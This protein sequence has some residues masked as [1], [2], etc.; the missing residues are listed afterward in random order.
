MSIISNKARKTDINPELIGAKS[1]LN[2]NNDK[3]TVN[4]SL[5]ITYSNNKKL[6]FVNGDD[7]DDEEEDEE[8][9]DSLN[10]AD[11]NDARLQISTSP[12]SITKFAL[13]GSNRNLEATRK[14]KSA[15][16]TKDCDQ[17]ENDNS[18]SNSCSYDDDDRL[19]E[20]LDY[21]E[22]SVKNS[23]QN[24]KNDIAL[25][26]KSTISVKTCFRRGELANVE[27]SNRT[28]S[29]SEHSSGSQSE[30]NQRD[31]QSST[32]LTN[33]NTSIGGFQS[34]IKSFISLNQATSQDNGFSNGVDKEIGEDKSHKRYQELLKYFFK[35]ACFFQIKSINYENVELSKS[36]GV[37]ST[38]FQNEIR[39]NTAFKENRNVILIFS[40]Q[41]SGAFQGFAR[42]TSPSQP[43]DR[44]VPWILPERMSNK[45]LGGLFKID[46]LCTKELSFQETKDLTNP[47]NGN[48]P[49]KIARDGQQLESSI[50]KRLCKLFPRDSKSRLLTCLSTLKR[51][52]SQRKKHKN[53]CFYPLP[54]RRELF[55]ERVRPQDYASIFGLRSNPNEVDF[56]GKIHS[57]MS[58]GLPRPPYANFRP[59]GRRRG[60]PE[61]NHDMNNRQ[62]IYP[63]HFGPNRPPYHMPI[64]ADGAMSRFA[65]SSDHSDFVRFN[66]G[67]PSPTAEVD[68]SVMNIPNPGCRYH[69]YQRLRR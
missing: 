62:Q 57:Y 31:D 41:Q 40:V 6:S 20:G 63:N 49:V 5:P 44:K 54:G 64:G 23:P 8:Q 65:I 37:W 7:D 69:P 68:L 2:C 17:I 59:F 33:K 4:N 1:S 30:A 39:L 32:P 25:S 35:D 34:R 60:Q 27:A 29:I 53:E 61:C 56:V 55:D 28:E 26:S 15:D 22:D 12:S 45:S 50:G 36:L 46:W 3:K 38:S 51:Q 58:M 19:S 48:K 24:Y 14:L 42:M 11:R 13:N 9:D 21:D 66:Q 18:S 10:S 47:Y 16:T 52:T 43:T 67:F